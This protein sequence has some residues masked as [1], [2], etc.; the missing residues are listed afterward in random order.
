[1]WALGCIILEMVTGLV[2]WV[3]AKNDPFLLHSDA[4]NDLFTKTGSGQ[5]LG[6]LR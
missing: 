3:G 1:V 2:P 6:K 4:K 5:T